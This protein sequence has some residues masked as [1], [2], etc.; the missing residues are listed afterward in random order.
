MDYSW[1]VSAG[2]KSVSLVSPLGWNNLDSLVVSPLGWNNLDS[3]VVSPLGWNKSVYKI[4]GTECSIPVLG[5]EGVL[6]AEL[7]SI[8]FLFSG[9]V[10]GQDGEKP[11][12]VQFQPN[13]KSGAL[14][15]VVSESVLKRRSTWWNSLIV[16]SGHD[17]C[18][19]KLH[20]AGATIFW[21][22]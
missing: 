15:T 9:F 5:N 1:W 14:L 12:L 6:T 11:E 19:K 16:I 10:K 13:Y 4:F 20:L 3:L 8:W 7:Y 2:N 17:F 21:H 18:P 22:Y